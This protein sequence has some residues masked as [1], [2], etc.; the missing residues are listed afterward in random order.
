MS[1]WQLIYAYI[2]LYN[3][4]AY[5]VHAVYLN[6]SD[7]SNMASMWTRCYSKSVVYLSVGEN[8]QVCGRFR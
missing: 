2:K 4:K 5:L 1:N 3:Y 7:N 8:G 6:F